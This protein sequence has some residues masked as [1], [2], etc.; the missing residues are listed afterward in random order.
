MSMLLKRRRELEVSK[1]C[2]DLNINIVSNIERGE[3]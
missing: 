3:F 1:F 2:L